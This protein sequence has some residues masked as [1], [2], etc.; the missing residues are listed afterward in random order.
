LN[1]HL[2]SD[3]SAVGKAGQESHMGPRKQSTRGRGREGNPG[4]VGEGK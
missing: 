3:L 4:F 1:I 2:S